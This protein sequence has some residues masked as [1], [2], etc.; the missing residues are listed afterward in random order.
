MAGGQGSRSGR[1]G[2]G[3]AGKEGGKKRGQGG[4]EEG[5]GVGGGGGGWWE[6]ARDLE[7]ASVDNF[8]GRE[9]ELILFSAVRCNKHGQ[10]RMLTYADVC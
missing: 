9:K 10:V 1:G 2:G 7:I 4:A 8:Q 5:A 3:R 6:E